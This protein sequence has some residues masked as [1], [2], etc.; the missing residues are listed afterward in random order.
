MPVTVPSI[1]SF[2]AEVDKPTTAE[3]VNAAF[4]SL[5]GIAPD[6]VAVSDIGLVSVDY[7]RAPHAATIDSLSTLVTN[8]TQVFVQ[9]W[10]DN[11]W[12]Y[13]TQLSKLIEYLGTKI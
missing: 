10:Y 4:R 3:A 12:G 9:A 5:A 7:I 11:E 1:L 2:V 6:R 8:G 13:V